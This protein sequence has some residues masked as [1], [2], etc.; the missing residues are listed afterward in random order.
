M[1]R[2]GHGVGE[3]IAVTERERRAGH[4]HRPVAARQPVDRVAVFSGD[5]HMEAHEAGP[6][7]DIGLPADPDHGQSHAHEQPVAEMLGIDGILAR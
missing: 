5:G 2:L 7:R 3:V 1:L 4:V 6:W